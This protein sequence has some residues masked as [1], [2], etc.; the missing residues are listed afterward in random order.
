MCYCKIKRTDNINRLLLKFWVVL[1]RPSVEMA[2]F[3]NLVKRFKCGQI[4]RTYND[5]KLHFEVF[6]KGCSKF[7]GK[8]LWWILFSIKI[9]GGRLT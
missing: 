1:G 5:I 7:R 2:Y 9:I 8:H 3:L 6:S 4:A